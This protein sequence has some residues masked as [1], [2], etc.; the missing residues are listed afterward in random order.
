MEWGFKIVVIL[1]FKTI[2]SVNILGQ[3]VC[4]CPTGFGGQL[5]ERMYLYTN[6]MQINYFTHISMIVKIKMRLMEWG[7]K[8]VVILHFKTIKIT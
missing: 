6:I 7:F 4:A 2:C 8:I 5:C 1:H 3:A